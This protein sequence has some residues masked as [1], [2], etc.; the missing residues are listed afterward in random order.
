[1]LVRFL[2]LLS[3]ISI[4]MSFDRSCSK[5]VMQTLNKLYDNSTSQ[6]ERLDILRNRMRMDISTARVMELVIEKLN[7]SLMNETQLVKELATKTNLLI[8]APTPCWEQTLQSEIRSTTKH[9]TMEEAKR[10][11]RINE[12]IENEIISLTRK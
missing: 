8:F 12:M 7:N 4:S 10:L 3:F 6:T 11:K 5:A 2:Y 1:M 9:G